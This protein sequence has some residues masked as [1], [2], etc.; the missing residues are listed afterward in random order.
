[1]NT[2][3]DTTRNGKISYYLTGPEIMLIDDLRR[4]PDKQPEPVTHAERTLLSMIRSGKADIAG[5]TAREL[6]LVAVDYA[7]YQ[8][9]CDADA[10][11]GYRDAS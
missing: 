1:M 8:A 5:S 3:P 11:L 6:A 4:C 9:R 10:A 7:A 2:I